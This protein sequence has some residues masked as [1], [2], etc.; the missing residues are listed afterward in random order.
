MANY[1]LSYNLPKVLEN[2]QQLNHFGYP[3]EKRRRIFFSQHG[4]K[5]SKILYFFRK[6]WPIVI[7]FAKSL[8][9]L[10]TIVENNK[11]K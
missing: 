3:T 6:V 5:T 1:V 8:R 7:E 11:K 4:R 2:E 10:T 9:K